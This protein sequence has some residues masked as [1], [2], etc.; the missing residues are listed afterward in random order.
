MGASGPIAAAR[1]LAVTGG[2]VAGV[3]APG[4]L[5]AALSGAAPRGRDDPLEILL[6]SAG[7]LL[8][9]AA[10]ARVGLLSLAPR[11]SAGGGGSGRRLARRWRWS[12]CG[13]STWDPSRTLRSSRHGAGAGSAWQHGPGSGRCAPGQPT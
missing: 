5:L 9:S 12:K 11:G 6:R 7:A 4:G 2:F 1:G 3:R 13:P 8:F 10:L